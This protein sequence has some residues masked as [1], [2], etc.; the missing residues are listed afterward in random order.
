MQHLHPRCRNSSYLEPHLQITPD[1]RLPLVAERGEKGI[2][3][4]QQHMI[5][6]PLCPSVILPVASLFESQ[7]SDSFVQC[8][9]VTSSDASGQIQYTPTVHRKPHTKKE[10]F[11]AI[12]NPHQLHFTTPNIITKLAITSGNTLLPL[13]QTEHD[14]RI[15]IFFF[16]EE[17]AEVE[18][19]RGT[20]VYAYSRVQNVECGIY[21]NCM[22]VFPQNRL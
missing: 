21:E 14:R 22:Y 11:V 17:C 4:N 18:I 12:Q 2:G 15:F 10:N 20:T 7:S 19:F 16:I 8:T 6:A 9:K 5:A 1:L 13:F 3:I